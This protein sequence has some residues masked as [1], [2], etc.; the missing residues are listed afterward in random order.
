[1]KHD[2]ANLDVGLRHAVYALDTI[3]F[4]LTSVS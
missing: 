2:S 4:Q 3:A 1:M